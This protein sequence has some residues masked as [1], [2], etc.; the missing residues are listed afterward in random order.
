MSGICGWFDPACPGDAAPGA[1]D[2]MARALAR[3][4]GTVP[5]TVAARYG[6]IAVAAPAGTAH[7]HAGE[8]CLAALWGR[9]RFSDA[10][11]AALARH[12]GLARAF[13]EGYAR[14][15][16]DVLPLIA[17]PFAAAILDG[18]RG[19]AL[20]ATDRMGVHPVSHADGGGK[21]VFGSKLDAIGAFPG[22]ATGIDRQ[23]VYDYVHF[24]MIPGPRTIHAGRTRLLPGTCL[25]WRAAGA[26]TRPYWEMRYVEDERRPF[27]ELREAFLARV[28]DAVR[29]AAAGGGV[30]AFLSGGTDSSTV[31]GVL[32]EVTGEPAR[33]YSIGFEARGYDEMFYARLAARHFGTR[34]HE[35]YVTPDDVVAAIPR[36]AAIHDQPFGNASAVPAYYCARLAREDGVTTLLGGDGGD[37]LFG[38]NERYAKQHLYSLYSDLPA[39]VRKA[40]IEPLAFLP[41]E[42][43][44]LG[45]A[46]RY[47]RNASLPMPERYDHYNLLE[48]LGPGTVFTAEF[49]SGVDRDAPAARMAEAYAEA[50][51]RA[52]VNRMLALDLRYTLAD[53]D[54]PK[55]SRSCELAGVEARYPLLDDA[56]VAF[57]A[58]LEPRLK[59]RGTRLRWFFKKALRGFL[60]E[61][62]IAKTKHGF[63]LPFGPWLEAHDPLRRFVLEKLDALRGR[64]I[65]RPAFLDE[66][67]SVH[68]RTH[69]GYY[70]TMVWVLMML[71]QWFECRRTG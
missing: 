60:P 22:I 4:D 34:H 28:R 33:T 62:I 69:A 7:L 49:L 40:L 29:A 56:V 26:T 58:R 43:G 52:L 54:L 23:A 61:E 36:V 68:V 16:A 21:L 39:F 19:T 65:V 44:V 59:L 67:T 47:L 53:N 6:A 27:A 66:L 70:G 30:G 1:I 37:E 3:F 14:R 57:S 20:V 55:V 15:G 64:G 41:P 31:A 11:L 8:H 38:G 18:A 17:G 42:A 35:Y 2:A 45:K 71:E 46:Q 13:A 32:T 12:H 24:H 50:R 25:E 63:G 51:A 5:V 10:E 48:R 9:P